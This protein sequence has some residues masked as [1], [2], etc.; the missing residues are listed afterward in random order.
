MTY[1]VIKR[2]GSSVRFDISKIAGAITK[3]FDACSLPHDSS[4]I[5]L[6]ALRATADFA[7]KVQNQTVGA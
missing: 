5:D 1:N 6:L 4:V 2:D 7:P 3:A